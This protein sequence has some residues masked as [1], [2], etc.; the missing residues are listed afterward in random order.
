MGGT[1]VI[2]TNTSGIDARLAVFSK[3]NPATNFSGN[4]TIV[5]PPSNGRYREQRLRICHSDRLL[6]WDG[7]FIR[8]NGGRHGSGGKRSI[9]SSG[10]WPLF[11]TTPGKTNWIGE[12]TGWIFF[13]TNTTRGELWAGSGKPIPARRR[14]PMA[15]QIKLALLGHPL[16]QQPKRIPGF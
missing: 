3:S 8:S 2:G 12:I 15:L 11:V 6:E 4:Y 5:I 14:I 9:N 13:Q 16:R 7:D 10:S 1:V